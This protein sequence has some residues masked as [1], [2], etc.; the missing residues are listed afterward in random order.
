MFALTSD[1]SRRIKRFI[2]N[3]NKIAK[4]IAW[5]L[6]KTISEK[7]HIFVVGAPRSGTTLV[8]FILSVHPQLQGPG[9]ETGIFMFKDIFDFGFTGFSKQDMKEIIANS[10]DIVDFFDK[11][12]EAN[13][14]RLGGKRFIEKTPPHVLKLN[15]LLK[16]FPK[17]QFINIVRDGR[18][19]YCSA[20]HHPNVVQGRNVKSYAQ[21]WKR[22][23]NARL[24][25]GDNPRVF[26]VRY[27]DLT[28][29]PEAIVPQ[30]MNFLGEEYDPRQ[31]DPKFYAKNPFQN[32]KKT[33]FKKLTQPIQ[34][35]SQGRWQK[36]MTDSE[37]NVFQKICDK[38]L[39]ALGYYIQ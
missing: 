9:Y 33:H 13:L 12:S 15:F 23:I 37:L 7:D 32:T 38:E 39:R 30:V 2:L 16:Y 18:D 11:F 35:T 34:M 3:P 36:E 29:T 8:K 14:S 24:K 20:K 27:E 22:C 31:I 6:P 26:D 19:C 10:K 17:S 5:R 25:I 21:Y 4:N 28:S 1:R